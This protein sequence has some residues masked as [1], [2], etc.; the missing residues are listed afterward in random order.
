LLSRLRALEHLSPVIVP[1]AALS[2]GDY[3]AR[4][5]ASEIWQIFQNGDDAALT[6]SAALPPSEPPGRAPGEEEIIHWLALTVGRVLNGA[7]R[8]VDLV[9]AGDRLGATVLERLEVVAA[10]SVDQPQSGAP[11]MRST[12]SPMFFVRLARPDPDL[13]V[14]AVER[15]RRLDPDRLALRPY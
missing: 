7:G 14:D 5:I 11:V 6:V 10:T 1:S 15:L 9:L 3:L 13:V 4:L 2:A 12:S 8:A